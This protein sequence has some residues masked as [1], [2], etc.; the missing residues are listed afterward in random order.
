[1]TRQRVDDSHLRCDV[2]ELLVDQCACPRH[3]GAPPDDPAPAPAGDRPQVA[4]PARYP[5]TCHDCGERFD[6]GDLIAVVNPPDV[7]TPPRYV[8]G[9]GCDR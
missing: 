1:M 4:F 2:T 3:R 7:F 5:G 8:C 9:E 6:V